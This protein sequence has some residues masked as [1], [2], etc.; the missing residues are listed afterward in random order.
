MRKT[1]KCRISHMNP[2]QTTQP[3]KDSQ[4]G[5]QDESSISH[6]NQHNPVVL[7]ATG[8][9]PLSGRSL[10]DTGGT[11][12]AVDKRDSVQTSEVSIPP[13]PDRTTSAPGSSVTVTPVS[14]QPEPHPGDFCGGQCSCI[15]VRA[16]TGDAQSGKSAAAPHPRDFHSRRCFFS[17]LRACAGASHSGKS[18]AST[19]RRDR[20]GRW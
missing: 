2:N 13:A 8:V 7:A 17:W 19:R 11:A 14:Q 18:A 20:P 10:V 12:P 15:R 1:K 6:T 4:I 3:A 16:C 5:L 9:A